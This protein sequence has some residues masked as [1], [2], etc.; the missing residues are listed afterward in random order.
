[1]P[2]HHHP[3]PQ[4]YTLTLPIST[5]LNFDSDFNENAAMSE[6]RKLLGATIVEA[7]RISQHLD[8]PPP[9]ETYSALNKLRA[10]MFFQLMKTHSHQWKVFD[11]DTFNGIMP[12]H[13]ASDDELKHFL[14]NQ[15]IET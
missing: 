13:A 8:P 15:E 4:T 10:Q 14:V 6:L 12:M 1:M 3:G 2:F 7:Q 11:Y 9:V 5:E